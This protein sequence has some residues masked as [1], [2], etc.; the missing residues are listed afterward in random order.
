[1]AN[2]SNWKGWEKELAEKFGV[3]RNTSRSSNFGKSESDSESH[4]VFSIE[5]KKRAR[6]PV[7]MKKGLEQAEGYYPDK[8]PIVGFKELHQRGGIICIDLDYFY[9]M[10]CALF[11]SVSVEIAKKDPLKVD[12][13]NIFLEKVNK[14]VLEIIKGE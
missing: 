12:E 7:L 3:K 5:A 14:Q 9:N 11:D 6:L 2:K 13:Y 8:I 10:Y 1:M 4:P